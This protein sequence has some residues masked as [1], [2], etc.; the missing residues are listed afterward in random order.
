MKILFITPND[1][2]ESN[3]GGINVKKIYLGLK[4]IDNIELNV[5]S[6]TNLDKSCFI[7]KKNKF[8]DIFSRFMLH[9]NYIYSI[10]KFK[11]SNILKCNPDIVI[12]SNSRL[13]FIA[14]DIKKHNKKMKVITQLDNIELDYCNN[15]VEKYN[16][17]KKYIVKFIERIAVRRDETNCFRY[18]DSIIFLTERDKNRAKKLYGYKSKKNYII[19]ICLGERKYN[20]GVSENKINFVFLGSLWYPP[21]S[22]GIKWFIKE[23]WSEIKSED[24]R[25]IIGGSNPDN[26][27]MK[28]NN[29]NNINIYPN[30][31][32]VE[33]IV[34]KNSIFISPIFEG[35]GMKVKIAEALSMGL[36]IV[37]T[38]E[39][40]VGYDEVIGS[41]KN[42]IFNANN[43]EEFIN[44]INKIILHYNTEEV[45]EN[46]RKIFNKYY[47]INRCKNELIKIINEN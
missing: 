40:L 11:K 20:L 10:W 5:C 14:K 12:L 33:K 4:S 19:P 21:N 1:I 32:N 8:L 31:S 35:A 44:A 13:G 34:P 6:P 24:I 22:K 46:A 42:V 45:Q 26:E 15:Y 27:L 9:S 38:D 39:A 17:I 25:L 43:K 30:F 36:P 18:S 23:V 47:C 2:A 29:K 28:F 37:A 16:G 7:I 41:S 3:G